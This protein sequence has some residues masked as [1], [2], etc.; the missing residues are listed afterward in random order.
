MMAMF[1]QIYLN[2]D[3]N[4]AIFGLFVEFYHQIRYLCRKQ[5]SLIMAEYKSKSS[6]IEEK[7]VNAYKKVEEGAIEG[8]DAMCEGARDGYQN[9]EDTVVDSYKAIEK[10][11]VGGYKAIENGVVETY[12]KI[13]NKFVETFLEEKYPLGELESLEKNNS[14][15][16]TVNYIGYWPI[17]SSPC[18]ALRSVRRFSSIFQRVSLRTNPQLRP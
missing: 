7:V 10:G 8:F 1:L 3:K 18:Q 9:I 12:K 14:Q 17:Y 11:V 6:K 16:T 4:D 2:F 15:L 13:E 5:I